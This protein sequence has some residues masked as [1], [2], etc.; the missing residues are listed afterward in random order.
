MVLRLIETVARKHNLILRQLAICW[1]NTNIHTNVLVGN[2]YEWLHHVCFK[3]IEARLSH[4]HNYIYTLPQGV[5]TFCCGTN[6][7]Q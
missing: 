7:P 6:S 2:F 5:A 4:L 3:Y 1:N